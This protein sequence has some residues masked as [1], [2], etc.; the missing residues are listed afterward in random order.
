MCVRLPLSGCEP[1][2]I[3]PWEGF[4]ERMVPSRPVTPMVPPW[5]PRQVADLAP[6]LLC[7]CSSKGRGLL[8]PA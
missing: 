5:E 3:E 6:S 4:A 7:P 8:V 2:S 1:S